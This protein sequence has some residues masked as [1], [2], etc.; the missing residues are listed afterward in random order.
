MEQVIEYNFLET[1]LVMGFLI[2]QL[3]YREPVFGFTNKPLVTL[4]N[5]A[6]IFPGYIVGYK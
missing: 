1:T 4:T 2:I 5:N 6:Q 3:N